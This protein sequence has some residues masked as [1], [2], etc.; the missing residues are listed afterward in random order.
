ML[1]FK[2]RVPFQIPNH[3]SNFG[4]LQALE[5]PAT[6]Y[7]R[8]TCTTQLTTWAARDLVKTELQPADGQLGPG[9]GRGSMDFVWPF[10]LR[11]AEID[12]RV[13]FL[14]AAVYAMIAMGG[15]GQI[16]IVCVGV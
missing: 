11:R 10:G 5:I 2:G 16:V 6:F 12:A 8:T 1:R 9:S 4:L 3:L 13:F 7:P 15:V 14:T